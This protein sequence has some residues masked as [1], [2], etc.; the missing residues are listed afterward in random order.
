[1][2][3]GQCGLANNPLAQPALET[4]RT[5]PFRFNPAC[6]NLFIDKKA[7]AGL[8]YQTPALCTFSKLLTSV[9]MVVREGGV[10]ILSVTL[11]LSPLPGLPGLPVVPTLFCRENPTSRIPRLPWISR[12]PV[13]KGWE[14][15]Q[16]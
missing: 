14:A 16:R 12:A 7:R 8:K 11:L 6:A 5:N 15:S 9:M 13:S 4:K 3:N 10:H 2:G 1:V